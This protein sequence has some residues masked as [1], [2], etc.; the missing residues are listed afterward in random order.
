MRLFIMIFDLNALALA[1]RLRSPKDQVSFL[2]EHRIL[3]HAYTCPDCDLTTEEV[4]LKPGTSYWYFN[5]TG[6]NSQ[7]S[8]RLVR[9][10]ILS[11]LK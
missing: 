4:K 9:L 5:C 1:D 11:L 6:C 7:T 2:Q 10:F 8:L 3:P